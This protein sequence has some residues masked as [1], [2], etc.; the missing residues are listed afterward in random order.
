MKN[1]ILSALFVLLI[2]S[3]VNAFA[4]RPNTAIIPDPN[5]PNVWPARWKEKTARVKQGDIDLIFVGASI[6]EAWDHAENQGVWSAYF[7]SRK[8]VSLG[9]GGARTENILWMLDNG[10]VDGIAPKVAVV[11]IGANNANRVNGHVPNTAE[12]LAAG[13]TAIV[14]RL[15]AKLPTTK[16]LLLRLFPR[17]DIPGANKICQ[18]ASALAAKI[19][20]N[21]HV[22]DLDLSRLF[23]KPDGKGGEIVNRERLHDGLHPDPVGNLRWAEAMEPTLAKWLGT[24]A[25]SA[26]IPTPKQE[27][28]FYNWQERHEAVK[29]QIKQTPPELVFIGD[30]ITHMIGGL[31]LAPIAR[32]QSV[33]EKHYAPRHALNLGFGWDRTQQVLWRLQNGEFDG[34]APKVAVVLIGTNNLTPSH[35]RGNTDAEIVAGIGAVCD[36]IHRKSPRTKI[37][38]LGL[39]PRGVNPDE[40]LRVR[41]RDINAALAKQK[42]GPSVTFLDLSGAFLNPD[43]TLKPDVTVDNLHPNE[44]GYGLWAAAIEPPLAR[45][46]GPLTP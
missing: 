37:L 31:P 26:T 40:L 38:L 43:G 2:L 15:R 34:I 36:A 8:A 11:M 25:N 19:A 33:W 7:G 5:T 35:A 10:E 39:L 46:F 21:R 20:D 22:F 24:P 1:I 41:I 44:A 13:I 45:L 18:Q 23:L 17:N 6:M 32:G 16:I 29:A 30:S 9:Y 12:E 28:D 27:D 42:F 3:A 14:G 4:Q